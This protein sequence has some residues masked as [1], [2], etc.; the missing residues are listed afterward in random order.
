MFSDGAA[1]PVSRM[2]SRS[3]G[4]KLV[5]GSVED[6]R[7]RLRRWDQP[8]PKCVAPIPRLRWMAFASAPSFRS[9]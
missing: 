2:P 7:G 1:S 9:M 4:L 3:G 8:Q 5:G 6:A